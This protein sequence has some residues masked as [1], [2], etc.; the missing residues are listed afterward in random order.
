M[1]A[2]EVFGA[3]NKDYVF[4]LATL[5]QNLQGD[6]PMKGKPLLARKSSVGIKTSSQ[7]N[8]SSWEKFGGDPGGE[9][10]KSISKPVVANLA[11]LADRV[12]D[13]KPGKRAI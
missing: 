8:R 7:N 6:T 4:D 3:H 1:G 9:K 11:N 13:A 2:R 5:G 12:K 10:P